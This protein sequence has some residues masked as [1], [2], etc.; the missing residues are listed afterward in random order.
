MT[1]KRRKA[2][3]SG[4]RWSK[5]HEELLLKLIK[6]NIK[7]AKI[8]STFP[9]RSKA[10][11]RSKIRKLKLKHDLFGETYRDEKINFTKRIASRCKLNTVFEAYSGVGHQTFIWST[12]ASTVFCSE[13][14][15][16]K[17]KKLKKNILEKEYRLVKSKFSDWIAY[18]KGN[19]R[20]YVYHGDAV[21]AA[22]S[23]GFYGIKVDLID[24]DT[25]GSTIPTI[26]YYINHLRPKY[27]V[28]THGEFHSLRFG[29]EDVLRRVL[30][31]R[32]VSESPFPLTI[33]SLKRELD[34]AVKTSCL[35]SHNETKDS[36]F[37]DLIDQVWLGGLS[38]GMLRRQYL[39]AK[40]EA[41]SDCL[42]MLEIQ[43][44]YS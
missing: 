26:P 32:S 43:S 44:N 5:M 17:V 29:R 20:I 34:I 12:N 6:N 23:L 31:H 4:K 3:S 37:A 41:T 14:N 27:L 39:L 33:E 16:D 24:L 7:I 28:I 2:N 35:R 40:P 19:K 9:K 18:S 25:C 38:Q 11:I 22:L 15:I 1:L 30:C 42:N 10:A 13:I 36:Y 8:Y 21:K